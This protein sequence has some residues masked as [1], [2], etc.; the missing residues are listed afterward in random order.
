MSDSPIILSVIMIVRN[1]EKNIASCLDSVKDL[2]DEIIVVDT[3]SVD[4]TKNI[5]SQ[6]GAKIFEQEWENNFSKARNRSIKE[7][8]GKWLLWIDADDIVPKESH[9]QILNALDKS[10]VAYSFVIENMFMG[11]KGQEFRQIRLFN[12]EDN[13]NFEG[14]I[15]ESL[16]NSIKRNRIK[17]I[18]LDTRIIHT[19]YNNEQERKN[20]TNRNLKIL[21]EEYKRY[22]NEPAVIMELGNSYYQ[23]G[24]YNKAIEFYKKI[25]DNTQDIQSDI[26]K[27]IDSLIGNTYYKMGKYEKAKL[28]FLKSIDKSPDLI[29]PYF[30]LGKISIEEKDAETAYKMFKK[31]INLDN[32]IST[33]AH[34]FS[35]MKSYAYAF[36]ANFNFLKGKF[37]EALNLFVE[38]DSKYKEHAFKYGAAGETAIKAGD[39]QKAKYFF[40]KGNLNSD[41]TSQNYSDYGV[42]LWNNGETNKAIEA[43]EKSLEMNN[44]NS[45]A[46]D[47]YIDVIHNTKKYNRGNI[48]LKNL[49]IKSNIPMEIKFFRAN[50]LKWAGN[51]KES[52]DLAL[53][54]LK[55]APNNQNIKDFLKELK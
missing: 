48:F 50:I 14:H 31:V 27:L 37:K 30:Y 52:K 53:E 4:N 7:A 28:Y 29:S 36:N 9:F 16:S 12:K 22:P 21:E 6:Y 54:L 45:S 20:K 19:G 13:L 32:Q 3:G 8:N 41:L 42:L 24:N 40:E 34:D 33:I 35:G 23:I 44:E 2:A 11:R 1:E 38:A 51:V 39:N 55:L 49:E 25:P 46:M 47:N 10:N 26:Y 15:H 5:A 17:I 18:N 43:F